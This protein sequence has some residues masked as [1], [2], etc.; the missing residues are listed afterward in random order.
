MNAPHLL[1]YV[2]AAVLTCKRR[3]NAIKEVV[4]V[5]HQEEHAYRDAITMFI[6]S[7]FADFDF[8]QAQQRL[9]E[10]EE[11]REPHPCLGPHS[12]LTSHH[13]HRGVRHGSSQGLPTLWACWGDAS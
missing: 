6:T 12:L 1:R 2:A 5:L 8:D 4:R 7:L 13:Y 9:K 11:V 10:C 3:R